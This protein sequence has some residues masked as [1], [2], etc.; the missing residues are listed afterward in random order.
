MMWRGDE[1]DGA[2][3]M[4]P[5]RTAATEETMS[6]KKKCLLPLTTWKQSGKLS[7]QI[8][9]LDKREAGQTMKTNGERM[10]TR[11]KI[12][13]RKRFSLK[14]TTKIVLVLLLRPPDPDLEDT[15]TETLSG[16]L[17]SELH[18]SSQ[19][20][21]EAVRPMMITKKRTTRMTRKNENVT[22][23][24]KNGDVIVILTVKTRKSVCERREN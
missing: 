20:P 22:E 24:A 8:P 21:E 4:A 11:T 14:N 15:Q 6:S 10:R 16:P 1:E 2:K 23:T 13:R 5:T 9:R 7:M 3:P 12:I 17:D 18:L 19:V